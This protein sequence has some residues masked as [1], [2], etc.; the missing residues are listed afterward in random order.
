[1]RLYL[2]NFDRIFVVSITAVIGLISAW[3]I[4]THGAESNQSETD[5]APPSESKIVPARD[6]AKNRY[7]SEHLI[8]LFSDPGVTEREIGLYDRRFFSR[9]DSLYHKAAAV[10]SR[11]G[12]QSWSLHHWASSVAVMYEIT[13]DLKY[14]RELD[15]LSTLIRANRDDRQDP[16]RT[17]QVQ[18]CVLPAWSEPYEG[19]Y[20]VELHIIGQYSEV[21]CRFARFVAEDPDLHQEFGL[22]AV[23]NTIVVLEAIDSWNCYLC[24]PVTV[25]P[26][27][28]AYY[29]SPPYPGQAGNC[30]GKPE[31]YNIQNIIFRAMI[32]L[33]QLL[34][35]DLVINSDKASHPLIE[36]YRQE[37]PAILYGSYCYFRDDWELMI[38]KNNDQVVEW[39]R[40]GRYPQTALPN[41]CGFR[42]DFFWSDDFG[43]GA[44]SIWYLTK[45][46]KNLHDINKLLKQT[47]H[48]AKIELSKADLQ[49]FTNTFLHIIASS[50]DI[51]F[52]EHVDGLDSDGSGGLMNESHPKYTRTQA[53]YGWIQLA[54]ADYRVFEEIVET[55][56]WVNG[57]GRQPFVGSHNYS[58]ILEAKQQLSDCLV[59]AGES[60]TTTLPCNK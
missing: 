23:R 34:H 30:Q 58:R 25:L 22:R 43:H 55:T 31:P 6:L 29:I 44:E 26:R 60:S 40:W 7:L 32:D 39:Y 51:F 4:P 14:L 46:W 41:S 11:G 5:A 9:R 8:H 10:F 12:R 19:G 17:D 57:E 59:I 50:D 24:P 54:L 27:K 16:P 15:R 38:H 45:L 1:M 18:R 52:K 37:L 3:R 49:R 21:M 56:F 33:V 47:G 28:S 42:E 53:T 35:S 20:Q 48:P 13:R 36:T 2:L